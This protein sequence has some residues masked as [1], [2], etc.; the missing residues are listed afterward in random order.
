MPQPDES[1]IPQGEQPPGVARPD[2]GDG[3]QNKEHQALVLTAT[4]RNAIYG[5]SREAIT[6]QIKQSKDIPRTVGA[7]TAKV[8]GDMLSV[9]KEQGKPVEQDI[10]MEVAAEVVND[11]FTIAAYLKVWQPGDENRQQQ[12]QHK[13]LLYATRFFLDRYPQLVDK[14]SVQQFLMGVSQGQYDDM[15][16]QEMPETEEAPQGLL[17]EE[18]DGTAIQ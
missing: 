10:L 14:Q 6:Q 2:G 17:Q 12:E 9:A 8:M 15:G 1:A 3:D 13:A 5:P 4:A 18:N 7:I 11:L 16:G